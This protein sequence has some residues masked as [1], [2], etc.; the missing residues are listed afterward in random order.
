MKKLI[1]YTMI[2]LILI[3]NSLA[4]NETQFRNLNLDNADRNIEVIGIQKYTNGEGIN[5]YYFKIDFDTIIKEEN[6]YPT[7]RASCYVPLDKQGYNNCKNNFN[8]SY[9][10][11]ITKN[12]IIQSCKNTLNEDTARLKTM[13]DDLNN[14]IIDN[15]IENDLNNMDVVLN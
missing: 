8:K 4:I 6:N 3:L 10:V 1:I 5:Q 14:I 9:C 13:Q 11:D 15:N 7:I 2:S 12:M